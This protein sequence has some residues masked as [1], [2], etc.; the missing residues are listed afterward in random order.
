LNG[1]VYEAVVE[2]FTTWNW[3]LPVSDV[4]TIEGVVVNAEGDPVA[5]A[6]VVSAGV[7]NALMDDAWT[8]AAGEFSVRAVKNTNTDVWAIK[9]SYVSD[10]VRIWV[11]EECPVEMVTDLVL[12][13]PA[14][15]ITLT[16]GETPN[17]LDS[18]LWIPQTWDPSKQGYYHIYY[19]NRGTVATDPYTF[20]DTDDTSSYGPEIISGARFYEGTYEYWVRDFSGNE[21]QVIKD[22]EAVVQLELGGQLRLYRAEDL[23]VANAPQNSY[24]HVFDFTVASNGSVSVQSVMQLEDMTVDGPAKGLDL[25]DTK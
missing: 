3:D 17:D 23:S 21:A 22:S 14:F 12:V 25:V 5:N 11:G 9:G 8:N 4:C 20:L 10:P 16:W 13:E 6:R 1:N 18:H 2:H 7:E 24:W 19:G 15:A